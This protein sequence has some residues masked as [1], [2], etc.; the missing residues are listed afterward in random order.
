MIL[1]LVMD[2]QPLFDDL[3][4]YSRQY[5]NDNGL[6]HWL[7]GPSGDVQGQGAA[8]D[9]D[10]DMAWALALAD[11]KWGGAGSLDASYVELAR[12]QVD[13]I[14]EHEI[15]ES[16]GGLVVAGDSW[17]EQ[18]VFNPSYFAPNQYRLFGVLTDNEAGWNLAIDKGY[19]LLANGLSAELGNLD[20]GLLPAWA[21]TEGRPSP[22]FDGASTHYQYDSARI[23]FRIA[24]DY[25]EFGEPRAKALL[26]KLSN[27]FSGIG[28]TGIVDGYELDGTPRPENT[29]PPGIQAALFVGAAGVG[30]MND[31]RYQPFVDGV[32]ELLVTKEMLPHSYYYNMSWH[33]FS[34][35]ML[36]GN[37]FDYTQH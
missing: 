6:M 10:E 21:D 33:V 24:Q 3:W 14:W 34:L 20:N 1:S 37:L 9:A 17:G 16:Y 13:R 27:F 32:Y 12:A 26:E 2:D 5:A 31:A 30:A 19:E 8:T 18:I 23:P 7:I 22:A 29:E 11:R 36:S 15:Y 28:A 25:C 4:S 35:T